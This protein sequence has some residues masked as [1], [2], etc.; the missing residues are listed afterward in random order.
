M[1]QNK[2]GFSLPELL[3]TVAILTVVGLI[4]FKFQ[5]DIFYLNGVLQ[6][7][8]SAHEETRRVIKQ[9]TTEL[10]SASLGSDGSYPIALA[11]S[12][13]ISFFTDAD[14]NGIREKITYYVS[15][16][17][18]KKSVV[19]PTGSPLSYSTTSLGTVTTVISAL[20]AT[21]TPIFSYYSKSYDGTA[22]STALATPVDIPSIRLVKITLSIDRSAA[23]APAPVTMTTAV[24]IRNLKDNL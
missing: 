11:S 21:T 19:V 4:A 24:M 1:L 18:L 14:N 20:G 16:G 15:S 8:V 7:D 5:G 13:S 10:R 6:D 3:V 2:K 23:R 12:T 9:F 22:S 17:S